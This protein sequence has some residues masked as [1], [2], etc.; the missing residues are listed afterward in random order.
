[1]KLKSFLLTAAAVGLML[2]G[3]ER[4][5]MALDWKDQLITT[6]CSTGSPPTGSCDG[7]GT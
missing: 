5:A 3:L 4:P 1:M 2:S 7:T 6:R